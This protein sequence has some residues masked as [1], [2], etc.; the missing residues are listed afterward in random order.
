M[1]FY[2]AVINDKEELLVGFEQGARAYRLSLLARL[3][4]KLAFADMNALVMGWNEEVKAALASLAAN[5]DVLRGAAVNVDEL[6]LCA[7]IVHPRQDVVC[8]GINYDAHAQE[9]GRIS[10][11]AFGGERPYTNYFSKRAGRSTA[12]KELVHSYKGL[13][14]RHDY[15]C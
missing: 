9:A 5:E 11:D 2:T 7:P 15:D 1:R 13:V 8:L 6:Q 3:M 12:T 14:D 10:D 4:P